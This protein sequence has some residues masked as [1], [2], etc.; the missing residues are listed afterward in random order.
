MNASRI[1]A[2]ASK[3][4][5]I[6]RPTKGLAGIIPLSTGALLLRLLHAFFEQ[7]V[8]LSADLLGLALEFVQELALFVVDLAWF[9][10]NCHRVSAAP[11]GSGQLSA[12]PA[13]GRNCLTP[14]RGCFCVSGRGGLLTPRSSSWCHPPRHPRSLQPVAPNASHRGLPCDPGTSRP[15]LGN[16]PPADQYTESSSLFWVRNCSCHR[17][18]LNFLRSLSGSGCGAAKSCANRSSS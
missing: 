2:R 17:L 5:G 14:S 3:S 12:A 11:H 4:P 9:S 18:L 6:R 16:G 10:S 15:G 7:H 1:R 8:K 13:A